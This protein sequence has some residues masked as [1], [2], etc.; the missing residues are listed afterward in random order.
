MIALTHCSFNVACVANVMTV[1]YTYPIQSA[2][3]S[4]ENRNSLPEFCSKQVEDQ[5][6]SSIPIHQ[7]WSLLWDELPVHLQLVSLKKGW[8]E[9]GETYNQRQH[10]YQD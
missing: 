10:Q 1:S 6:C 5:R 9:G 4:T 7:S 8:E 2:Q 3:S